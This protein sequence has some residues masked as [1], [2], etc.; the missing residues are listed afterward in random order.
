MTFKTAYIYFENGIFAEAR[1]FG[2]DGT[3]VGE[4]VFNTSISGYQEILSDPSYAGQFVVFTM[5]EIGIV[6]INEADFESKHSCSGV[7]L[8]Q[9]NHYY[10]NFR[11]KNNLASLLKSQGIMGICDVNTREITKMLMREGS[12]RMIA[13]S[14]I[15]Q[16][17]ELARILKEQS[18]L[19]SKR[20]V[21]NSS[22]SAPRVHSQGVFDFNSQE[23]KRVSGLKKRIIAIDC[24]IK[25]NIL[26][27]LVNVG[28]EVEL[29]P[30][31][32]DVEYIK[33]S[34]MHGRIK[35]LFL[36]NGPGD[37]IELQDLILKIREL[38]P[39]K[40]PIFGICLG[41]QILS[42]AH[43]HE[44]YKLKFG[45]HGGNHPVK[46]LKTGEIYITAQ[47]HNY[48]IPES[49]EAIAHITHRDLFDNTIE[50]VEYK[51]YPIFSVQYHPESSPGPREA[52]G[53]FQKFAQML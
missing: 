15:S 46:D 31:D 4:A 43:G 23:Y 37:P 1:S 21:M 27:E 2:T 9:Y 3:L 36:S 10:S 50:G 51:N 18:A 6:G 28:L 25:Q 41:H 42:L 20:L 26:N 30:F 16:K 13:S 14:E 33:Q 39:I 34:F 44:T 53:I 8:S 49:I 12:V 7:I 38:I 32:F 45:H 24:G 35:G 47:N 11:S 40:I 5:P 52:A 22:V 29:L 17:D 19:D 48:A